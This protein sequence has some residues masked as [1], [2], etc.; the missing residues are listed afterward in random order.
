MAYIAIA[1]GVAYPILAGFGWADASLSSPFYFFLG[2]I[3]GLYSAT[4]A[5]EGKDWPAKKGAP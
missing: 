1:A 3:L 4:A 5:L 2:I